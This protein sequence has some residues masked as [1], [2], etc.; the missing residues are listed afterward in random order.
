MAQQQETIQDRWKYIDDNEDVFLE[1]Y[2]RYQNE[3]VEQDG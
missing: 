2:E 1:I 3:E